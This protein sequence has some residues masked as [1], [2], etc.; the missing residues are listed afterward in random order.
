[1]ASAVGGWVVVEGD[2]ILESEIISFEEVNRSVSV[3][4]CK[5]PE[6]KSMTLWFINYPSAKTPNGFVNSLDMTVSFTLECLRDVRTNGLR[7]SA[8]GKSN[9]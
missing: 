8:Y 4:V 2:C 5:F 7:I 9:N 3:F 1:V 6:F